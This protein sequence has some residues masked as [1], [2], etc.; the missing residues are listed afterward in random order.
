MTSDIENERRQILADAQSE[1]THQAMLA[2]AAGMLKMGLTRLTLD[3]SDIDRA[4]RSFII[5]TEQEDGSW[6]LE[7]HPDDSAFSKSQ[8]PFPVH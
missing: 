3:D 8:P 2:I 5:A 4:A 1:A 6:V 7:I